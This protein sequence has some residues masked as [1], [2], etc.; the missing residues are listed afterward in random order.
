MAYRCDVTGKKTMVGNNVPHSKHKTRRRFK[1]NLQS[2]RVMING[3]MV[4]LKVSAA[5]LKSLYHN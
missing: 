3:Q 5:G 4:K 2:K 1:P